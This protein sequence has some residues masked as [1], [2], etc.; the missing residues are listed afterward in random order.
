[1]EG[2]R[3]PLALYRGGLTPGLADPE[4]LLERTEGVTAES[5]LRVADEHMDAALDVLLG[6]GSRLTRK[7]LG[8]GAAA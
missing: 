5:S 1:V 6:D 8:G 3:R 2:L 4:R 7:L